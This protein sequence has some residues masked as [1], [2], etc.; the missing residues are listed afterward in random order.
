MSFTRPEVDYERVSG[1]VYEDDLSKFVFHCDGERAR[2]IEDTFHCPN[3]TCRWTLEWDR[4]E[5]EE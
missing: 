3:P 2:L 4:Q 1:F 5:V